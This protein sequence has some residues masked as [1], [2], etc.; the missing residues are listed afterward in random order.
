MST[1]TITAG[2]LNHEHL[3]KL[4]TIEGS[5]V[6]EKGQSL[7][8]TIDQVN[9]S[10]RGVTVYGMCL[11]ESTQRVLAPSKAVVLTDAPTSEVA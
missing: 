3:E 4:L 1:Q 7:T 5:Q 11:G 10:G 8:M 2:Q 6:G 9:H